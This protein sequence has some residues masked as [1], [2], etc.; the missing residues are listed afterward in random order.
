MSSGDCETE[1][2]VE[3]QWRDA[4]KSSSHGETEACRAAKA[5]RKRMS[6]SNGETRTSQAAMARQRHHG[7]GLPWVSPQLTSP[8][9]KRMSHELAVGLVSCGSGERASQAKD[10]Y[11]STVHVVGEQTDTWSVKHQE[12]CI[13]KY[14]FVDMRNCWSVKHQKVLNCKYQFVDTRNQSPRISRGHEHRVTYTP[15]A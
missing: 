13:A 8:I 14:Q 4:N 6:S 9:S 2:H 3:R 1:G 12:C 11:V 15:A 10:S 5:R 7:R